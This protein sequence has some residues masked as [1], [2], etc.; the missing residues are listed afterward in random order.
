MENKENRS[1][2]FQ[3][4]PLNLCV[5][6]ISTQQKHRALLSFISLEAAPLI[7][8]CKKPHS[9]P[10]PLCIFGPI[11]QGYAPSAN[12]LID[13]MKSIVFWLQKDGIPSTRVV[14][15]RESFGAMILTLTAVSLYRENKKSI[16]L[17][18]ASQSPASIGYYL[19]KEPG[20]L[21]A[22]INGRV[23]LCFGNMDAAQAYTSIPQA[24]S[25]NRKVLLA[26]EK[27]PV[28]PQ[29]ASLHHA[30]NTHPITLTPPQGEE[31]NHCSS[32]P[33]FITRDNQTG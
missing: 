4:M 6:A 30:L 11:C 32:I 33:A 21:A 19:A 3:N 27:D 20:R 7:P 12:D 25:G 15:Y 8:I 24:P 13:A 29:S 5:L 9:F 18:I 22:T 28:I 23:R 26:L 1:L 17:L 14:F 10:T 2:F 16:Q 31:K